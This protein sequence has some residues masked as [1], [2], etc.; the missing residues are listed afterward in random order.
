M[1]RDDYA[2]IRLCNYKEED[3]LAEKYAKVLDQ[4][5]YDLL[6]VQ[7][8]DHL[9][10][11]HV[12]SYRIFENH[13]LTLDELNAIEKTLDYR[14]DGP[15]AH[16]KRYV[17]RKKWRDDRAN[18]DV[19]DLTIR[20]VAEWMIENIPEYLERHKDGFPLLPVADG[21]DFDKKTL[22]VVE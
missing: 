2:L 17:P 12:P 11:L 19:A 1:L 20:E 6:R 15:N 10:H 16:L 4:A 14:K 7:Y 8:H 9:T 21:M 22:T 3:N 5:G 18:F 13:V